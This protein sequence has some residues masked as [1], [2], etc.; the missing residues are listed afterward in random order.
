MLLTQY[1][2]INLLLENLST[3]LLDCFS[4]KL[5]GI[6][7]YGS[8]VLG[9]FN[10]KTSDIDVFVILDTDINQDSFKKLNLIHQKL[11][12]KYSFWFSRAEIVY[13]CLNSLKNFKTERND[14]AVISPRKP[15]S[16][17]NAGYDW[18]IN[19]Y[20]LQNYSMVISG[21]HPQVII[22]KISK[23]EFASCISQ[24][25]IEWAKPSSIEKINGS[26]DHQYNTVLALCRVYCFIC[27]GENVSKQKAAYF[28]ASKMKKWDTLINNA[29]D[30]HSSSQSKPIPV[31]YELMKEFINEIS[32][33]F[34]ITANNML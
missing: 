14:I 25:A 27:N 24:E 6:Y 12:E 19:Y 22:P 13:A 15:F 3:D 26:I 32:D 10:Y 33:N 9:D 23:N 7:L 20:L 2:D 16:I 29:L 8:L 21:P 28:V 34:N 1:K 31:E 18:L 4:K 17:K 5:T 30:Y 11:V